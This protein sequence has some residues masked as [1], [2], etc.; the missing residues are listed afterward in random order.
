MTNDP[1]GGPAPTRLD[2]N[3]NCDGLGKYALLKLRELR[4]YEDGIVPG[5]YRASIQDALDTLEDAGILDWGVAGTEA[6]F[7]VIRLKDQ[8][9]R[10]ALLAYAREARG[11]GDHGYAA[12]IVEMANRAGPASPFCKRPD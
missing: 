9:A 12:D 2:R 10:P 6:E 11:A 3:V 7:F 8:Y 5:S 4:S 1:T